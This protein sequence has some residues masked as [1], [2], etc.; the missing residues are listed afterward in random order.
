LLPKGII[1]GGKRGRREDRER[2]QGIRESGKERREKK[3]SAFTSVGHI[4]F[5]S[6]ERTH[7]NCF[8]VEREN[9]DT[10]KLHRSKNSCCCSFSVPDERQS[11]RSTCFTSRRFTLPSLSLHP[12][13]LL[14]SLL[15][16]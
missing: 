8:A 2:K 7:E 14:S 3:R 10:K 9:V 12:P 11:D 4:H 5:F 1:R 6:H 13:P 15:S 16:I